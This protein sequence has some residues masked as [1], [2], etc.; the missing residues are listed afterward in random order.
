MAPPSLVQ[1]VTWEVHKPP[2]PVDKKKEGTPLAAFG[3]PSQEW[4]ENTERHDKQV[5]AA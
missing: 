3:S 5:E 2:H 1:Q 4:Q